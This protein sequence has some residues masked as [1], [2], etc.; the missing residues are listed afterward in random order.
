MMNSI[1]IHKIVIMAV[2]FTGAY[3]STNTGIIA[4]TGEPSMNMRLVEEFLSGKADSQ[5]TRN[6]I[7]EIQGEIERN[8]SNYVNYSALA[9]VCDYAGLYDKA[10][11]AIKSEIRYTPEKGGWDVIYG[12]LARE[13]L[14]IGKIDEVRK[15]ALKSLK[16][17]PANI[18]TRMHLLSYYVLKGKHKEAGLELKKMSGLD[19][20]MDFYYEIYVRCFDKIQNRRDFIELFTESVKI[21]P[22]SP[23]SHRALGTAIRDLSY[24]DLEKN[25]PVIMGAFN[26]ARE[27]DPNYAPTYIS[28]ANTYM[29]LGFK[30]NDRAYFD[31]SLEW[32]NKAHKLDPKNLK[33]S[34]S[35]GNIFLAM[36]EYDK[37][38]EKLEY[39][40]YNGGNDK[41]TT[42]LLAA[43]YNNKA[44]S[45]YEMGKNMKEGLKVIDKAIVLDPDNGFILST[46]AE[47]L[48]KMKRFNEAY[49][50]IQKAMKLEPDE[51]GIKQDL[52]NIEKAMK[53]K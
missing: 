16:F 36:E 38:I 20:Q 39:T 10:L 33:V 1:R 49:E 22:N 8:P 48:Y 14:N 32:I 31:D 19:K 17:S 27:L 12:N 43:A 25:L 47:L 52:A 15:P 51:P 18:N 50:C 53:G 26:K 24:E 46:K 3:L 30:T 11:E 41:D 37:G 29:H 7:D 2:I 40:F 21:N 44:Y 23:L 9:F 4:L 13:Y 35:M 42:E 5:K 6:V 45:Y 34:Y 28:I